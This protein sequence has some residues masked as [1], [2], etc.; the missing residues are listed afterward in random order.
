MH[1]HGF[2]AFPLTPLLENGCVDTEALG[3]LL[4]RIVS[5]GASSVG[6]LGSTGTF[7]FLSLAERQRALEAALEALAGR[8]P[9]I[10]GVG[11]IAERDVLDLARHAERAGAQGLLAG[12]VA[13][14][15]L[16][17]PEV[18]SLYT[19]L[20]DYTELGLCIYNNPGTTQYHFPIE[21][22]AKLAKHPRIKGIKMPLPAEGDFAADLQA[23][24][25]RVGTG[26]AIGYSG[27]QGAGAAM[28]AGADG[29]YSAIGGT[30]PRE[31]A[32]LCAAGAAGDAARVAELNGAWAPLWALFSEFGSLRVS[33]AVARILDLIETEL[34]R[35]LLSLNGADLARVEA[36]LDALGALNL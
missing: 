2:S 10:A 32:A 14:T 28:L 33:H 27:D 31:M 16:L 30:L 24:R 5:A 34:P 4:E 18:T 12:P 20:A 8:V 6:F 22:I 26:L 3:V 35:P 13:Y 36:G 19:R 9:L 29:F 17:D 23:L 1:F 11:A 21:V 25:A 7:A 15:P